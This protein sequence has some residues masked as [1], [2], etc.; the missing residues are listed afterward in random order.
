MADASQDGVVDGLLAA[1]LEAM[2]KPLIL[3]DYRT[4]IFANAAMRALLRVPDRSQIEGRDPLCF[5]HPDIHDAVNERRKLLA[6]GASGFS[7]LPTKLISSD[8]ETIV[9][10]LTITPVDHHG[11]RFAVLLYE[12]K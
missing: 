11:Y 10:E 9:A 5:L 3:S 2:P 7:R 8:G 12:P 4:I 1:A 6:S